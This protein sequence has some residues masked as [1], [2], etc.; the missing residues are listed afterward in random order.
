MKIPIHETFQ[1]T[2]QGEGYWAGLPVDFIRLAGC[3][4]GCYFCDTG[5]AANSTPIKGLIMSF[6][7]I[8]AELKTSNVVIS[9]GEPFIHKE[10]PALVLQ[11]L[12][13]GYRVA[14]ETSGSFWQEIDDRA[15]VTLSPKEHL[16][17]KYPVID[18]FW[19]RCNEVKIVISSG[20]EL[21]FY[22]DK[23]VTPNVFLQME[24]D[25]R[26]ELMEIMLSL[27]QRNPSYR[28]SVQLHKLLN[29]P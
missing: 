14:I 6:E 5:Y 12:D 1:S 10:L 4:V 17:S 25:K 28:L 11:L 21:D 7:D 3:P 29:L 18:L 16:N 20:T 22:Q 2:I 19:R 26:A 23:I 24:W 27:L 9:G 13:R 15:W 8:L